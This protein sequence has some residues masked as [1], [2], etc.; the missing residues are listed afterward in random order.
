M[1][2]KSSSMPYILVFGAVI[3]L[4]IIFLYFSYRMAIIKY[5]R[6]LRKAMIRNGIPRRLAK[7]LSKSIGYIGL[8]DILKTLKAHFS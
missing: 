8:R 7:N 4:K 3:I 1:R 5:R 2:A 6:R